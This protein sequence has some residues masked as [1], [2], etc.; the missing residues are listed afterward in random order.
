MKKT[1]S[2]LSALLAFTLSVA[3][4]ACAHEEHANHGES[5]AASGRDTP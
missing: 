4:Q 3:G 5:I 2:V 1:F